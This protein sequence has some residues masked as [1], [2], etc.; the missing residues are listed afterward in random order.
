MHAN[1]RFV[2][3]GNCE[4]DTPT[5]M[6]E[7]HIIYIRSV[8]KG[9]WGDFKA[10]G[11]T[12]DLGRA[13]RHGRAFPTIVDLNFDASALC[14]SLP[15]GNTNDE[16][17]A[18]TAVH[19]F[20]HA[21]GFMHEHE[22]KDFTGCKPWDLFWPHSHGT[23]IIL[24]EYDNNSV[25]NYCS[26]GAGTN[27][28][29]LSRLDI[30]GLQLVYGRKPWGTIVGPGG[31]C[32]DADNSG[33]LK[34]GSRVQLWDCLGGNNQR[35]LWSPVDGTLRLEA[36]LNLCLDDPSGGKINHTELVMAECSKRVT[37]RWDFA[38]S[39]LLTMGELGL[40]K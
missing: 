33:G 39:V 7:Q 38:D 23:G 9:F 14:D 24:T 40:V 10:A 6:P 28:G 25:M 18:W 4:A 1:I 26:D 12:Q 3:W 36:N 31:R 5:N 13:F 35:W 37:E 15:F 34:P 2:G 11:E 21:L 16:C 22:R 29:S 32:F 30:V 27:E 20:G 19:E 8:D 17:V